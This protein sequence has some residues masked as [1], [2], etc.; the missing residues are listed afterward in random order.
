MAPAKKKIKQQK[1]NVSALTF[2]SSLAEFSESGTGKY[3]PNP[4]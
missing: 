3:S 4:P 1:S 2:P